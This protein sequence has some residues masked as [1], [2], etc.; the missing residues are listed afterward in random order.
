MALV[1]VNLVFAAVAG[2]VAWR[3]WTT[4]RAVEPVAAEAVDLRVRAR[5]PDEDRVEQWVTQALVEAEAASVVRTSGPVVGDP[6][7]LVEVPADRADD[8]VTAVLDVLLAEGYEVRRTKGRKVQ[9]RRGPDRVTVDV[10]PS[11]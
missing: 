11:P 5:P 6:A 2:L 8:V 10:A 3:W 1:G 7:T 4:R 9:L